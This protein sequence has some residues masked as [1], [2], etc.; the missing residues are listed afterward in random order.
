MQRFFNALEEILREII[1]SLTKLII[2]NERF[3]HENDLM[4][5]HISKFLIEH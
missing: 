4:G 5:S 1:H 2:F 3:F